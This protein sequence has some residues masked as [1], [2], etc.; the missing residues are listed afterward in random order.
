M[1]DATML[2]LRE[3]ID[4]LDARMLELLRT[5]LMLSA[6]IAERKRALGLPTQD[7]AREAEKRT[8][9]AALGGASA[10]AFQETL[11]ALSRAYQ[12]ALPGK[13]LRCGLVGEKLGHSYSPKIHG[14]LGAYDYRLIEL[15]PEALRA[16]FEK[17]DFDGVNVTI[18][19]KKA[20]LPLCDELTA[21][22]TATICSSDSTE[23]GPA[24]MAKWPPPILASPTVT[25]VSAGWNLRLQ[26]L[27]VSDTR[28]TESTISRE[29]TRSVSIFEVSP[30]RPRTVWNSPVETWMPRP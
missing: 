13:G 28:L 26:H 6:A 3:R 17:R 27:K 19:Y 18:P 1:S 12:D 21:R 23:Q 7:A 22:A 29:P 8:R 16:F 30:M 11:M 24:I 25:T 14:L 4:A 20:V 10:E 9:A 5:R 2:R 15:E